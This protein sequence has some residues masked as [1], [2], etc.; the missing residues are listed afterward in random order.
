MTDQ[1]KTAAPRDTSVA[2]CDIHGGVMVRALEHIGDG[3][4]ELS[5]PIC[6]YCQELEAKSA[7]TA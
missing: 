1:D 3:K 4:T 6:P 7:K 2:P 5:D